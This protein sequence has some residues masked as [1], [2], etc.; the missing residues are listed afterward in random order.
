MTHSLQ[1]FDSVWSSSFRTLNMPAEMQVWTY[2]D[3]DQFMRY[4]MDLPS[5]RDHANEE[6]V[7]L[8]GHNIEQLFR[9]VLLWCLKYR[10]KQALLLLLATFKGRRY[11]PPRYMISD[12]LH[13]LARYFLFNVSDP[14]PMAVDAIWFL[15]RKFIEGADDQEQ[16]F[17]VDQQVIYN[18]LQHSDDAR[19][20]SLY[21]L[22]STNKALLHAD[23]MLHFL[24]RFVDMG[25]IEL[26]MKL[27]DTIAKTGHEL[28]HVGVQMACTKLLQARSD[29]QTE[30]TFRS[31]I[32]K[33]ILEL[34]VRPDI[35]MLNTILLN[36]GEGGD[37][38]NAWRMYHLAK[39]SALTP[40]PVTLGVLLKGAK[41]SGDSSNI[42]RVIREIQ[43][44]GEVLQ[45]LRVVSDVLHAISLLSPGDEFGAMLSFYKQYCDVRPL[46]ELSLLG[47]ETQ[48][49]SGGEG[50]GLR[51]TS[52][53]LKQMIL[54]YIKSHQGSLGLMVIYKR[55]YQ[56]VK[57]NH[58]LIAPLAVDD[59]V[60]N[61]FIAAFGK[62]SDTLQ[63]CTTV[64]KHMLEFSSPKFATSYK[65]AYK[66]PTVKTWTILI[67][68]Y[69]SWGQRR[70]AQKVV[71]MML[72]RGI[73]G[74]KFTWNVLLKGYASSQDVNA[75]ADTLKSMEVARFEPDDY[76]IK[77]LG[78]LWRQDLLARALGRSEMEIPI[79]K[80][81]IPAS[82]PSL[83]PEEEF[84]AHI[85]L[86]WES[87][88]S[89]RDSQV[90]RYWK[91]KVQEQLDPEFEKSS[92][93]LGETVMDVL[94]DD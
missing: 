35:H 22:L 69:F 79:N 9:N 53:I 90:A 44:N 17:V 15:T 68:T 55:Y 6:W 91:A 1:E 39:G 41:L 28:C 52:I 58:P 51:P 77:A 59:V 82:L 81:T 12:S 83:G 10:K 87:G 65:V 56:G 11:R 94:G 29:A 62:K 31:Y 73:G 5:G 25:N 66:A 33:H 47:N 45:D 78:M 2:Q 80:S 38:D 14:E 72:E 3:T 4:Y 18:L 76:T 27:L 36:A 16:E 88:I 42:E 49:P 20:L 23:S 34:G 24:N 21:W 43:S 67:A 57:E 26:A 48:V 54:A 30:Y 63:H 74:D 60:A 71:G 92:D 46:Q 84:E 85:N 61:A 37:F 75:V 50:Q 7:G 32:L 89:E 64:I 86:E 19:V 40:D 8:Q 93:S 13:F 70:A